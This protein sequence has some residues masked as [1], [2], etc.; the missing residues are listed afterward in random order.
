MIKFKKILVKEKQIL[1]SLVSVIIP[2]LNRA[3]LLKRALRSVI[4]QTFS[5]NEIIVVDNGSTDNTRDM[6]KESFQNIKYYFLPNK[7]VSKARNVG[8][9][10]ANC[11][12]ISF[13]DSDDEW[14]PTKLEKQINFIKNN[15]KCKF[16]HSNEIWYRNGIHLNQLKKH[17]KEG[18][19]IFKNCLKLCCIS[20]S[21]VITKKNV[22]ENYGLFDESFQVCEDYEMWLRISAREEICFQEDKLV[23]KHG[24]HHDQL[25]KKFW[26]M[27]RFRV[28]AIEKNLLNNNF[29]KNQNCLAIFYLLKKI[30]VLI[31]GAKKRN[32]IKIYEEFKKKYDYWKDVI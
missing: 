10:N 9:K 2:T 11:E 18:G 30:K 23:I 15:S 20:P 8:I 16:L 32:N 27:D 4:Y 31:K 26:G 6:I 25:S 24:G 17:K 1:N 5:P 13:L 29:S 19:N 28:Y 21:S 12:W 22:F 14:H 3:D 7:G